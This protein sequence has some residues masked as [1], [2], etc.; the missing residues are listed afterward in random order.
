MHFERV[1]LKGFAGKRTIYSVSE[2][3][4]KIRILAAHRA[5]WNPDDAYEMNSL[6]RTLLECEPEVSVALFK[7]FVPNAMCSQDTWKS[8]F[9]SVR[10]RHHLETE[11]WWLTRLKLRDFAAGPV[12][13]IKGRPASSPPISR[14]LLARYDREQLYR[15]VWEQPMQKLA[16]EYGISDVALSKTCR[17]LRVPVPVRGFW[18]KKE[19]GVPLPKRPRLPTLG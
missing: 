3:L 8:L 4:E 14:Q 7:I 9:S 17:K 15:Q 19:A 1:G 13:K 6:R 12:R 11:S 10:F 5:I 16:K 18:A 2:S